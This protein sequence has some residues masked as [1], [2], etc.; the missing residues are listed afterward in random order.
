MFR[1][2]FDVAALMGGMPWSLIISSVC[3]AN[4][5][6][7]MYTYFGGEVC[8]WVT[9]DL[10][11]LEG[12]VVPAKA[13]TESSFGCARRRD[14][15]SGCDWCCNFTHAKHGLDSHLTGDNQCCQWLK[16]TR[17]RRSQALMPACFAVLVVLGGHVSFKKGSR[18]DWF[19]NLLL[20]KK[21][22]LFQHLLSPAQLDSNAP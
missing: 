17:P 8:I 5:P 20:A 18:K 14:T 4:A 11:L 16:V 19:F 10:C 12:T 1:W 13:S 3:R 22:F 7:K 21:T 6:K 15:N 9:F 2:F